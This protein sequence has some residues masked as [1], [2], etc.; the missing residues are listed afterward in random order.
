MKKVLLISSNTTTEPFPV[1]PLG[2]AIISSAMKENGFD[3]QQ[4][5]SLVEGENHL[6]S[7][8]SNILDF[9]PDVIGI[10]IRNIDN[11]DSL[12][13]GGGWYL[14]H[15]K[16]LISKIRTLTHAPVIIG[17]P[18]FSIMPEK[19]LAYTGADYGV[20]GE[21]E[22]ALP[23]LIREI[24]LGKKPDSIVNGNSSRICG[25]DFFKP[26]YTPELTDY[27]LSESGM[28]NYQTKRGC[29]HRCNY[30]SYPVIEGRQF[31]YQE[32]EFVAESILELKSKFK[33]D[34]LFFTDSVFNDIGGHYLKVAEEIIRKECNIKWAGYFRPH[35]MSLKDLKLL[36][37]SGLYAMEVGSDA[38]CD[39]TLA[40]IN[41]RFSF[42]DVLSFNKIS[43]E[44][45]IPTAN[46]FMFGGPSETNETIKESL[47]NIEM[48]E[49]CAV[50][51]FSGIRILPQTDL[52]TIALNEGIIDKDLDL[53]KPYYY[54]S[55]HI[56]KP[57]ME[58]Q[59]LKSF[60]KRKDRIFPPEDG[61]ARLAAMHM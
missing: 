15:V 22:K 11:V 57:T 6:K 27:Y 61:Q 8:K 52:E 33:T 58:H 17:G 34:T 2:M 9:N 55:P 21:G 32:P 19:I 43:V 30:C 4:F 31:R 45:E 60:S 26:D 38:A 47:H 53:L 46:F 50:F 37:R 10:S 51:V 7:L 1:Y 56:D 42:S 54:L 28:L 16:D 40:G 20:I 3:V 23:N 12:S 48:L 36:K 49:K 25:T 14:N 29:P 41:K 18:A 5:D 13:T 35:N 24:S 59:I 44:A 39:Q